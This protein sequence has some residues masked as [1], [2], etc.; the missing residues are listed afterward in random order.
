[1]L[2]PILSST[3]AITGSIDSILSRISSV[4]SFDCSS[5]SRKISMRLLPP[6]CDRCRA[7][8]RR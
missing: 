4:E 6:Y 3:P 7:L 2:R 5:G 1:M 8:E